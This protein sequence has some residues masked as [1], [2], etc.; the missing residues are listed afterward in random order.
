MRT[1]GA[2]SLASILKLLLD[3]GF[4]ALLAILGLASLIF[5]LIIFSGVYALIG[6]GPELPGALRQWLARDFV[7]A[8]PMAILAWAALT[9]IIYRLRLIFA[10]LT[11][12]DPFVPENANHLRA[13]AL[14]IAVY[15]L[16]H[17]AAHGV[18]ALVIT[19]LGR[20]PVESGARIIP[21]FS[22]NLAAWFSVL[23]ILVLAEV[24]R[25]GARL[26]DE[27]KFTI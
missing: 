23:A 17:Y 3:I 14:G 5:V 12:G 7:L 10:T 22:L 9:F 19:L 16:L 25:E 2:G 13:I 8:L 11:A 15:Q 20:A 4:F 27:Q 18:L 21:D 6:F 24:F 1:L 26:R